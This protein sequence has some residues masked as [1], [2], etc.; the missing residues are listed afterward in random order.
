[1]AFP[2]SDT[3]STTD[4]DPKLEILNQGKSIAKQSK[5][6]KAQTEKKPQNNEH[7][8]VTILKLQG[9]IPSALSRP[10]LHMLRLG[11]L[12]EPQ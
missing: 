8:S 4:A 12:P 2:A 1:M 6:E 10:S 11:N 9:Q 5:T 3:G 7:S